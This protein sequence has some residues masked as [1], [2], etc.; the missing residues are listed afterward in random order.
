MVALLSDLAAVM[1]RTRPREATRVRRR[2]I[3]ARRGEIRRDQV[4]AGRIVEVAREA[5]RPR[6]AQA[7]RPAEIPLQRPAAI[8]VPARPA[9]AGSAAWS[10][11]ARSSDTARRNIPPPAATIGPSIAEGQVAP[12]VRPLV[13][14]IIVLDIGAADQRAADR[15]RRP[16]SGGCGADSGGR[17]SGGTGRIG[18]RWR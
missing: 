1:S 7:E 13:G 12:V 18:R 14:Q 5:R 11:C 16:V 4:E 15:R 9:G 17:S 8:A 2:S 3:A 10:P 6:G